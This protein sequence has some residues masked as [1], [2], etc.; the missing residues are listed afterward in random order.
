MLKRLI[1]LSLFFVSLSL[2][3]E[4]AGDYFHR[5][6]QHYIFGEKEKAKTEITTG[7]QKFPED[8]ELQKMAVLLLKEEKENQS[9]S[10]KNQ[11]KDNKDK[12]KQDS[13]KN[14]QDQQKQDQQ[15]QDQQKQNQQ[16]AKNDKDKKEQEKQSGGSQQDKDKEKQQ[17]EQQAQA[18]AAAAGKM[19]PQQAMRFLE[20]QKQ[21]ERTLIFAPPPKERDPNRPFKD[22]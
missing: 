21:H 14:Q 10:N 8:P 9:Q 11:E 18:A 6:A 15:K 12:Q 17:E 7:L 3:A 4:M 1:N 19:T 16:Q 2:K 22:W 5:G 20:A 13:E